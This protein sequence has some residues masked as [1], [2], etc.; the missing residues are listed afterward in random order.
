MTEAYIADECL[1]P[2]RP[3]NDD[4]NDAFADDLPFPQAEILTV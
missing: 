1:R 4:L 3:G 2:I